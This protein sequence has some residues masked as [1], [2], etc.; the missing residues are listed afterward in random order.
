VTTGHSPSTSR[1][2]GAF[3]ISSAAC[4]R[5]APQLEEKYLSYNV[6]LAKAFSVLMARLEMTISG[7]SRRANHLMTP[8]YCCEHNKID[9]ETIASD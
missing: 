5:H 4:R 6:E 1:R 2:T 3:L 8:S 7:I 9:K